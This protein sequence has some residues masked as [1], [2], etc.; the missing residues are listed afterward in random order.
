MG[1]QKQ[2]P[3][4][5]A[6]KDHALQRE[7]LVKFGVVKCRV[8]DTKNE[9]FLDIREYYFVHENGISLSL[10]MKKGLK[11][12]DFFRFFNDIVII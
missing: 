5:D 1:S 10:L 8:E 2:Y 6:L 12:S 4:D 3:H 11:Q 7:S 9:L